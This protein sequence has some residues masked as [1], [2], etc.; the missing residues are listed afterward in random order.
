MRAAN[1]PKD[2][3][4]L[5]WPNTDSPGYQNAVLPDRYLLTCDLDAARATH[6]VIDLD[7]AASL[8]SAS[9]AAA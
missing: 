6:G 4:E 1:Q 2:S 7:A 3:R 8:L 9:S 5:D